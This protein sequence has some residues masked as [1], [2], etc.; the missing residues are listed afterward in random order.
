MKIRKRVFGG[1][2]AM[3]LI[4]NGP[5]CAQTIDA[6][7]VDR[8]GTKTSLTNLRIHREYSCK[9]TFY[10]ADIP[11][12]TETDSD[13]FFLLVADG[14]YGIEIPLSIVKTASAKQD[15]RMDSRNS[16]PLWTVLLSDGTM[17]MG[18]PTT[19]LSEPTIFKDEFEFRAKAELGQTTI[20]WMDVSQL[21]FPSPKIS[22]QAKSNGTQ[23][24]SLYI[25]DTE[26]R[27]LTGSAF[28]KEN[29]NKNGCFTGFVYQSSFQFV[30]DGRARYDITWDRFREL[31]F[32]KGSSTGGLQLISVSGTEY[33]GHVESTLGIQGVSRM[34]AFDLHVI[35]PFSSAARRL[36]VDK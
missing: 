15:D 1:L 26:K 20:K 22:Y 28:M 33:S 36:T 2:G 5:L 18:K 12:K 27:S 30:T 4:C 34:G 29:R 16:N 13:S 23:S 3:F 24:V 7:V 19:F 11:T 31:R 8:N 9:N 17:V 25:S 35:V 14:Q 21:I 6:V 32:T 10:Y